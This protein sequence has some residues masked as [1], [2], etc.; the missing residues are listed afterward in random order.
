[1]RDSVIADYHRQHTKELITIGDLAVPSS[2]RL[3]DDEFLAAINGAVLIDRSYLDVARVFGKDAGDLLHRLTTNEMRHLQAG[4]SVVNIFTTAKGR[5]LDVVQ[6]LRREQD[7]LLITSPARAATVLQWIDKYTFVEDVRGEDLTKMY[8]LFS[9][10]GRVSKNFAGLSLEELP[11]QRF[12]VVRI[13]GAEAILH[14]T[15]G[16]APSGFNLIVNVEAARAVW[17]F[18]LHH[19]QP[20]GFAAYNTLRVHE[21]IPAVDAEIREHINPHEAG[22]LGFINFEKGCYIGQEVIARLDTYDKV[23]RRLVG[24]EFENEAVPAPN[25]PLWAKEEEAGVLT[26]AVYSPLRRKAIGLGLVRRSFAEADQSLS[27]RQGGAT[28]PCATVHLPF[29]NE[30]SF[31][32]SI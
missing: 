13:G 15:N 31:S 5:I 9:V 25:S 7:Y 26:S 32:G 21:G 24:L 4:Q 3:P 18:L 28:L 2:Y 23:Q 12:R 14:H 19:A 17:D 10:F 16:I 1:M 11:S 22:L 20:I 6:M 8:A 29:I 27:V 30:K